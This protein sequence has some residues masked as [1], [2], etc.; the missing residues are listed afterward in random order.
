MSPGLLMVD[1]ITWDLTSC[2][3]LSVSRSEVVQRRSF[4]LWQCFSTHGAWYSICFC[5]IYDILAHLLSLLLFFWPERVKV[6]SRFGLAP[7]CSFTAFPGTPSHLKNNKNLS[8]RCKI[9]A[10]Y[11]MLAVVSLRR[12]R[13]CYFIAWID[14]C[15]LR[16]EPNRGQ[17]MPEMKS[18][19]RKRDHTKNSK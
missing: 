2:Q 11:Q 4:R 18:F 5:D 6:Y 15:L 10:L 9:D 3:L 14:F 12:N 17:E 16:P 13:T 19:I 8:L 1:N 7:T